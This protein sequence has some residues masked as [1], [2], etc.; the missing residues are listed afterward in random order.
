MRY[1]RIAAAVL[2]FVSSGA[3]ADGPA[4]TH[5]V[6]LNGHTFTLPVGFDIEL[7]AAPPVVQRPISMDFDEQGRLYVTDSSGSNEPV[8]QQLKKKPHRV[9]RL[10]DTKGSGRFDKSTVFADQMMFPEGC[11]WYAGSLYVAAPPSIWKLTDTKGTGKADQREEW[12]KGKTLTGCAN[13]LHGPYLGPDGWI[14]WCKGA[15]AKQTYELSVGGHFETRAAHIFRS[16]PDGSRLEPVMTGGMDN[17]VG[18]AF[19]S[20]GELIFSCTFLQFPG[21]GRRDGLIH[22]IYGGIYGKDWDVIHDKSHRWTGPEVMPV[23]THLGAAAPCGLI[24]YESHV[25][26][27][28]YQDNLFVCLFNMQKVTRHVLIPKGSTFTT[29]DEDFLVS[30]NKDFHPTDVREDADGSLLVAD[31]GGWYK[32]CCPTSQLVKPDVLGALYRIRRHGAEQVDDPRGLRMS[33]WERTRP[34]ELKTLLDDPRPAVRR[35]AIESLADLRAGTA[36][37]NVLETSPSVRARRNAVWAA[38][39]SYLPRVVEAALQDRDES[40]RQ[41]ALHCAGLLRYVS[42]EKWLNLEGSPVHNRRTAE[43]FGR[44]NYTAAVPDILFAAGDAQDRAEEHTLTY[45]LIEIAD[46]DATAQG[47]K[48]WNPRVR[49]IAMTALDQMP[50]GKLS[51]SAVVAGLASRDVS[52]KET[53]WWIAARHPEWGE[54][55]AKFLRHRLADKNLSVSEREAWAKQLARMAKSAAVQELLAEQVG[56]PFGTTVTRRMGLRAMAESRLKRAPDRWIPALTGVLFDNIN[57]DLTGEVIVTL[58]TLPLPKEP[59][60][61]LKAALLETAR[62][63]RLPEQIRLDAL[64]AVPG[65]LKEL[66]PTLFAL[67][68]DFLDSEKS[69]RG[70]TAACEVLSHVRLTSEQLMTLAEALK[71]VGPMEINRLV[72]VFGQSQDQ[73]VAQRLLAVLNTSPA[74]SALQRESLRTAFA[75]STPVLKTQAEDLYASLNADT[76]TQVAHLQELLASTVG[77]DVRRGQAV[78][79][80]TKAACSSCHAIGYLGGNIGP[81]LTHIARIRTDRDLLEAIV[82]P[83]ASFVRGY[84]PVVVTM[85]DGKVHNGVIR[86]DAADEL[87]LALGANQE[88]RLARA[89]IEDVQPSRVSIMP[90]GLEQQLTRT[91]LAD[92]LAFLKACK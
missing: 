35:R 33:A 12:F 47:L 89:D 6:R 24:R 3:A 4:K 76:V 61:G 28:E 75:K 30:D 62:N 20:T 7:A 19:T 16:Q 21:G 88:V 13:D 68:R 71:A 54:Q 11:L 38:T 67:A 80:S 14:Y 44:M 74:R 8:Q 81:D 18:I 59:P 26:G 72:E 91:E 79:N 1:F 40:V 43:A 56:D 37:M 23:M 27:P 78:F 73:R 39:R 58:R 31:T 82:F 90:A 22:A 86:R 48:S 9:L 63:V 69:V 65:G 2:L 17:P 66:E 34:S 42:A 64:A 92:L 83:S 45:A 84:E 41:A 53:A 29:R 52:L 55:V 50:K 57:A 5:Q 10:E 32:L 36:L 85:R 77:G 70:R 25:F 46:P 49:R 87:V 60:P 51:A 15:F